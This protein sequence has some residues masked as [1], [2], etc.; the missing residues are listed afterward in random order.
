M[1]CLKKRG[2]KQKTFAKLVSIS[3]TLFILAIVFLSGPAQAIT[4]G[5]DN[6]SSETPNE[7][8]E[9]S[10]LAK[11]DLH[12]ND[13]IPLTNIT[14]I[15]KYSNGTFV[16]N[17]N[18]TFDLNADI[19][20]PSDGGS[21]LSVTKLYSQKNYSS[22]N[23]GYGYG[24]GYDFSDGTTDYQNTSFGYGYSSVAEYGYDSFSNNIKSG[25]SEAEFVYNITWETPSVSSNTEYKIEMQVIANDGSKNIRYETKAPSTITVQNVADD[26]DDDDTTT[27]TG[28]G[29]SNIYTVSD[30]DL[31]KGKTRRLSIG[32]KLKFKLGSDYHTITLKSVD[33]ETI[34]LEVA[35]EPQTIILS[36]GESVKL[37]LTNAEY[38]DLL[39]SFDSLSY[40]RPLITI[41]SI[42]EKI[43]VQEVKDS[44]GIIT[45]DVVDDSTTYTPEDGTTEEKNKLWLVI[46]LIVII[47]AIIVFMN[48][49]SIKK[50]KK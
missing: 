4:L 7:D 5:F 45:G 6:F 49:N 29:S 1:N 21:S 43:P 12:T 17:A 44:G 13:I 16:P 11:V 33:G 26:D 34:T 30:S 19:L 3:F 27:S 14:I 2:K 50:R 35:S 38:Y 18:I 23:S 25:T 22:S 36:L 37:N 41:Q 10:F 42:Y 20:Y 39:I 9:V 24:Y 28:G 46:L 8:S 31:E 32:N 47:I 48:Q 40:S 15:V